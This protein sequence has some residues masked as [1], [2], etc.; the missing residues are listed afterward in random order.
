MLASAQ[1]PA[2]LTGFQA[3]AVRAR[4]PRIPDAVVG[5]FRDLYRRV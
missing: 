3:V 1:F 5:V 2:S 4:N